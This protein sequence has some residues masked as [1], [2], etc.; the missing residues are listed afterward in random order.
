MTVFRIW[1]SSLLFL[2]CVQHNIPNVLHTTPSYFCSSASASF[3]LA[4]LVFRIMVF[5]LFIFYFFGTFGGLQCWA[6]SDKALARTLHLSAS[7]WFIILANKNL[8]PQPPT[9]LGFGPAPSGH[10]PWCQ[11]SWV[12]WTDWL[13]DWLGTTVLS[14]IIHTT[15]SSASLINYY[16]PCKKQDH[17]S[18]KGSI[19]NWIVCIFKNILHNP[20]LRTHFTEC[21]CWIKSHDATQN[22]LHN[23]L[24]VALWK[25]P[26]LSDYISANDVHMSCG[27]EPLSKRHYLFCRRS[28]VSARLQSRQSVDVTK[29]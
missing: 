6:M 7:F 23:L 14:S 25:F 9:K 22:A 18:Y 10:A 4:L 24:K 29:H 17:V 3:A 13:T 16:R 28:F 26:L 12:Y 1:L 5:D 11:G 8:Q 15:V 19:F 2:L 21:F 27:T 20:A